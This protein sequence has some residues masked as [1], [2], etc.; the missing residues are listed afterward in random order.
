MDPN[1]WGPKAWYFIH[2]IAL[3]YSNNPTDIEKEKY[4][5]FFENLGY[6]LPCQNCQEHYTKN[7]IKE[8]LD[9]ALKNKKKLFKWT[10][11]LHNKVNK[12]IG[13]RIYSYEEALEEMYYSFNYD[14]FIIGIIIVTFFLY[15]SRKKN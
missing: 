2:S 3:G 13:K 8:E 15:I 4:K 6:V 11:D 1:Y 9:I 5:I 10:V 7:L 12:M 14:Y